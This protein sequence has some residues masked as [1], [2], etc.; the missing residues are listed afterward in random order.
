MMLGHKKLE[1]TAISAAYAEARPAASTQTD[2]DV[3]VF[4]EAAAFSMEEAK[5]AG[6]RP[7]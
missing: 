6:F 3:S 5:D 4:P 2:L 1:T 7:D